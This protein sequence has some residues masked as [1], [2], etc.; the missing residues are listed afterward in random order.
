MLREALKRDARSRKGRPEARNRDGCQFAE[1]SSDKFLQNVHHFRDKYLDP[2][3]IPSEHV[4]F[5]D[6]A[7]RAWN[8]DQ[9]ADFMRKKRGQAGFDMSEP[10]FLLSVMDRYPNWCVVVCVI[11][12]GQ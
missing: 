4:V 1:Q 6:E 5:F 10:A 7:Q 11:G 9:T 12:G 2:A 8:R 3:Q